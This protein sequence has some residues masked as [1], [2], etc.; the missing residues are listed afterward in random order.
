MEKFAVGQSVRRTED[1]RLLKG[2]GRFLND[3]AL[4]GQACGFVVRSPYAHARVG[5]IDTEAAKAAPGVLAVLTGAELQADSIGPLRCEAA[6][7][8]RGDEPMFHIPRTALVV[9]RVRHV[10]DPVAFIIIINLNS[11]I[12]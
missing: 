9:D 6:G 11:N 7:L 1:P 3:V 8:R 5:S 12:F 4:P 10:G 2:M